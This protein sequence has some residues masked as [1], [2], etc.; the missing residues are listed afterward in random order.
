[1]DS[2]TEKSSWKVFLRIMGEE[3]GGGGPDLKRIFRTM[4]QMLLVLLVSS[5]LPA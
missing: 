1:M 4:G 2:S 3:G 5:P